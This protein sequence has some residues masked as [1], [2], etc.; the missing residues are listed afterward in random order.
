MVLSMGPIKECLLTPALCWKTVVSEAYFCKA[1]LDNEDERGER[2]G[3]ESLSAW[4]DV[5]LRSISG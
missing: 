1:S 5:A 3:D 2:S 4:L